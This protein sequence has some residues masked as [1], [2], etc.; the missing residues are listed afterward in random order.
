MSMSARMAT[1]TKRT[2]MAEAGRSAKTAAG[3]APRTC[4]QTILTQENLPPHHVRANLRHRLRNQDVRANLLHRLR[5]QDVRPG[6]RHCPHSQ[7]LVR[8]SPPQGPQRNRS[9]VPRRS[10][11]PALA[12]VEAAT[13]APSP[14]PPSSIVTPTHARAPAVTR[15]RGPVLPIHAQAAPPAHGVAVAV[16]SRSSNLSE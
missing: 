9:P 4:H 6:R 1:S 15:G 7:A 8:P 13:G 11:P 3:K 5:N 16:K 2:P 12:P 10:H 14:P